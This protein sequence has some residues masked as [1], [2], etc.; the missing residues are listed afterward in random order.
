MKKITL[1]NRL[2]PYLLVSCGLLSATLV[3]QSN[4]IIQVPESNSPKAETEMDSVVRQNFTAPG[5]ATFSEIT[6]R[7]LFISGREPPSIP[8]PIQSAPVRLPPLR[9]LLEGIV[10]SPAEKVAVIFDLSSNDILP[11]TIGMQHQGWELTSISDTSVT[12]KRGEQS[13]QLELKE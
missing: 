9:L 5:V 11:L 4:N 7:P 3:I 6:Q 12:F 1:G 8:Q 10:I 2:T 13:Q